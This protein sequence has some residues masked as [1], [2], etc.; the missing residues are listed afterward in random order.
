MP[1]RG[2][3]ELNGEEF[4]NSSRLLAH[5][6]P[7]A[8]ASDEAIAPPMSCACDV[9]IPYDDTWP[10]LEATL[11]SAS[12]GDEEDESEDTEEREEQ[13]SEEEL[14]ALKKQL[15]T[16]KRALKAKQ[17]DFARKLNEAR[18]ALEEPT[19]RALVLGI[20]RSDLDAIL[21]RYVTARRQEIV[22]A[23][24]NWWEKYRVTLTSIEAERD[25]TVATL[26]EFLVG[27]GY[28]A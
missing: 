21:G 4:T 11:K 24:E 18:A 16:T 9:T 25:A 7:P 1:F 20:V 23:F 6:R 14:A 27:L 26:H 22:A 17:E 8:P 2:W 10:E 5:L 3:M 13:L 28:G 15:A 19:A 12:G